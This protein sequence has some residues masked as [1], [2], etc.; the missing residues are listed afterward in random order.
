[1]AVWFPAL[2]TDFF[3]GEIILQAGVPQ[4]R[5][6][7]DVNLVCLPKYGGAVEG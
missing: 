6:W 4:G 7:F 3:S 2:K 5:F 1:L